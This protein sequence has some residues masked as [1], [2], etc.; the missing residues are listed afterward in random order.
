MIL[1]PQRNIKWTKMVTLEEVIEN[2]LM[3]QLHQIRCFLSDTFSSVICPQS[4]RNSFVHRC[5]SLG[6]SLCILPTQMNLCTCICACVC[7]W[8]ACDRRASCL[9]V[10]VCLCVYIFVY[11]CN[12]C[13]CV[14][15]YINVCMY[16][17]AYICVFVHVYIMCV[18][19]CK[20][21]CICVHMCVFVLCVLYEEVCLHVHLGKGYSRLSNNCTIC[22]FYP[23]FP[24][25]RS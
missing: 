7:V 18:H 14:H 9:Y 4:Q 12:V 10:H 11:M 20:C 17:Y 5:C 19:L 21:I 3:N 15:V 24:G 1:K 8:K 16:M 6:N 2:S 25:W 22:W 13:T 23:V